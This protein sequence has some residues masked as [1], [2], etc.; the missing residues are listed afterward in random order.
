MA[1][2]RVHTSKTARRIGKAQTNLALGSTGGYTGTVEDPK[3]AHLRQLIKARSKATGMAL[4]TGMDQPTKTSELAAAYGP[5]KIKDMTNVDMG[6]GGGGQPDYAATATGVVDRIEY[7]RNTLDKYDQPNST[8][9]KSLAGAGDSGDYDGP[10]DNEE[11]NTVEYRLSKDLQSGNPNT[12]YDTLSGTTTST[13]SPDKGGEPSDDKFNIED[14]MA[15]WNDIFGDDNAKA[16]SGA[17]EALDSQISANARRQSELSATS[18][19]SAMGGGYAA[20]QSQ[21]ALSAGAAKGQLATNFYQRQQTQ[22]QGFLEKQLAMAQQNGQ[23]DKAQQLQLVMT[24]LG[25]IGD[26]GE[27]NANIDLLNGTKF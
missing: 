10:K 17:N 2:G 26:I 16:W 9:L 1:E 14:T 27:T 6:G 3:T 11:G 24:Q 12:T 5:L 22:K 15:Q 25:F 21:A 7:L 19:R 8:E 23:F 13:T 18:G 4:P 20:G